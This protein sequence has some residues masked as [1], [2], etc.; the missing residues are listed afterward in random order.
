M[1]VSAIVP[2][3][4][5][6]S[7]ID[8]CIASLLDQSL[9][10]GE[11]EA[12]FVDDGSTDATPARLDELAERHAHVRVAHIPNSGWPG[13]P[14]NVGIEMAGGEY[15]YFVDNDDWIGREALERLYAKA[16]RDEADVVVGKIV[17]H[18]RQTSRPLFRRNRKGLRIDSPVLLGML[19]PHKL[20][21]RSL[22]EEH[23]I[24]FPE[25]R[26]RLEDHVFV[27][28]AYLH[29]SRI[30]ILADYPCY[31][32][33]LRSHEVNA[34]SGK[35]DPVGYYQ[36]L[37]DVLD[38]IDEHVEP[39]PLRDRLYAHWYRT[40]LLSRVGG[41]RDTPYGQEVYGEIRR[42]ALERFG[43]GAER[44]LSFPMRLRAALLRADRGDA[45]AR[46]G[47]LERD[48]R[49]RVR[50]LDADASGGSVEMRLRAGLSARHS[51]LRFVRRG[52][53]ILLAP[54]DDLASALPESRL[55]A[56]EPIGASK[57]DL[58]LRSTEHGE[59]LKRA[60]SSLSL[61][62][63]GGAADADGEVVP[64]LEAHVAFDPRKVAAGRALD[65]GEWQVLARVTVA[66]FQVEA[67]IRHRVMRTPLVMRVD[68]DGRVRLAGAPVATTK[69]WVARS[70]ARVR[71]L[72]RRSALLRPQ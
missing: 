4:N 1:K 42:L 63:P 39:G 14:R 45:L 30:S 72:L 24:R 65:A 16:V 25:G 36:N 18:G 34:S 19:T 20:F 13:R 6:G 17:G 2:V 38:L 41:P 50:L 64:T 55:D 62:R 40:K 52:E 49:A 47:Q 9:G 10:P 11:Y 43:E 29:A 54:P 5:P 26:V 28:H 61:T 23:G 60:K 71:R 46:L 59:F 48:M 32:W 33:V 27:V 37:R 66:G 15:V 58:V 68:R 31:H 53:R 21:R 44:R 51:A 56:T 70:I 8:D 57:L 67:P 22:L 7:H 3:Y 35:L 12:I 69:R